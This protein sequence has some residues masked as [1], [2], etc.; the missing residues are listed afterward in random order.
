M[1]A[2]GVDVLL[3]TFNGAKHLEAQLASVQNQRYESWR[4]LARDDGSTDGTAEILSA[5]AQRDPRI[6]LVPDPAG[7][8]GV[9][10]GFFV[11]LEQSTAPYF[12]F[13]DQ[14]DV[15]LPNK[16][17]DTLAA[18]GEA[19]P[20][21]PAAAFTDLCVVDEQAAPIAESFLRFQRID[22]RKALE[23]PRLLTQNVVVGCTLMG[24]AALREK[25][26][27]PSAALR[28]AALMHDGW[29]ALV[30][31]GMGALIFLDHRTILYR[32]HGANLLGAKRGGLARYAANFRRGEG[33]GK[34]VGYFRRICRQAD[35]FRT[36]YGAELDS[37]QR[38]IL[39]RLAEACGQDGRVSV[40]DYLR[41]WAAGA[42]MTSRDQD[43]A[44]AV[45]ILLLGGRPE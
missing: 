23:W 21:R 45:S 31:K 35:A 16:I 12:M 17:A 42:R 41:C 5:W 30:A 33:L 3:S 44:V 29:V 28:E 14:D 27:A 11:L 38:A 19:P 15:W 24:N 43:L 7:N 13:C 36:C 20:L 1:P 6:A 2:L 4:L 22:V 8:L 32:Q 34:G 10:N 18:L 26:L 40:L 39:D 37:A 9:K 25:A